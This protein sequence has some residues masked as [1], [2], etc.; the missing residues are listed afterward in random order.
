MREELEA[1]LYVLR[2]LSHGRD[3]RGKGQ[4]P[5]PDAWRTS[6]GPCAFSTFPTTELQQDL[7][8]AGS[9]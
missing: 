8:R 1:M 2:V 4:K 5:K 7:S 6:L 9:D 3:R